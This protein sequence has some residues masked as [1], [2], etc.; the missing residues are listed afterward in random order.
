MDATQFA[1]FWRRVGHRIIEGGGAYWYNPQP[2]VFVSIPFHRRLAP[3]SHELRGLFRS[4]PAALLRHPAVADAGAGG[5][6]LCDARPYDFL[7]LHSKAR[8]QTRRALER[9]AVERMT[10]T[11]LATR[12][13]A[14][15]IA[16]LERQGRDTRSFTPEKWRRY[17]RASDATADFETWG[18]FVDGTLAAFMVCALVE[19]HYSIL[20]QSSATEFLDSQPNNALVFTVLQQQLA[21]EDVT[22]VSYGLKSVD[23]TGGLDHFKQRMGFTLM[24]FEEVLALNPVLEPCLSGWGRAFIQ[25][26]A[27]RNR[28]SDLWRK[29]ERVMTLVEEARLSGTGRVP[30]PL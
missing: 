29:A 24:P 11:D 7:V 4:G 25:R 18:A 28:G 2:F 6:F 13:H 23:D 22:C 17:C 16:T 27:E 12:G 3:A 26:K 9:C 15:N 30:T 21:R 14:L 8:N 10:F 5:I 1:G 20:H 19:G